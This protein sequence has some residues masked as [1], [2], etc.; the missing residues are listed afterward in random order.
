MR[1]RFQ[2][3]SSFISSNRRQNNE[4]KL[5]K[6]QIIQIRS[7][8]NHS[9]ASCDSKANYQTEEGSSGVV[10]IRKLYTEANKGKQTTVEPFPSWSIGPR[11]AV[12][13]RSRVA[14]RKGRVAFDRTLEMAKGGQGSL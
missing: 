8:V 14:Q 12:L 4:A 5:I 7:A 11:L 13:S 6:N 9:Y 10:V 3:N 1:T 2:K